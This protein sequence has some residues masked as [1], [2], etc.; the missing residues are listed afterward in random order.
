MYSTMTIVDN[1][2]S[3]T[4]NLLKE[5][6]SGVLITHTQKGKCGRKWMC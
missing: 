6:I 3:Y 2:V 1:A 4:G 5:E